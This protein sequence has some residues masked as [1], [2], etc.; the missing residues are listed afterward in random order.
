MITLEHRCSG[1]SQNHA[2]FTEGTPWLKAAD[3][4]KKINTE[5]SEESEKIRSY[6]KELIRLRKEMPVIQEG[7][8]KAIALDHPSIYAYVR[9]YKNQKLLVLNHFYQD[10]DK[11]ILPDELL[12]GE[13]SYVIGNAG[14]ENSK[15]SL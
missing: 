8:Y 2:S 7:T 9:E 11:I 15:K 6:Y 4:Y 14:K 13:S 1:I 10:E 3:N 12:E 5:S